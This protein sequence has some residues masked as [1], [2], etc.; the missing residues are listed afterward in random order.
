MSLAEALERALASRIPVVVITGSLYFVAQIRP[1]IIEVTKHQASSYQAGRLLS[2][3]RLWHMPGQTV[4]G[5][6]SELASASPTPGGGGAA[7]LTA[8]ISAALISMVCNLTI[9]K[10]GYAEHDEKL[11]G[12]LRE[13][14]VLRARAL[15][16]AD[17]DARAFKA[18][19]AAYKLARDTDE[20]KQT[21]AR[22]IQAALADAA[23]VPLRVAGLAVAVIRLAG[24]IVG[25]SNVN[26]LSDVAVAAVTAGAALD[27][28]IVNVEVNLAAIVDTAL[29]ARL[30][31][32]LATLASARPD[33]QAVARDVR[34]RISR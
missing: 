10:R 16:L 11:R 22:A 19:M 31:A 8:A 25:R 28:A 15:D 33:A 27:A 20:E 5:W 1:L 34:A 18:V 9:G 21:R 2:G 7:A 14:D 23:D 12:A 29:R 24:D 13:A 3:K 6:L 26:V 17:A 32:Q 4:D 30:S